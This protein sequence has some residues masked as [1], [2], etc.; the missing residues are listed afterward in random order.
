MK[1]NTVNP[2]NKSGARYDVALAKALQTKS[3]IQK[4][5]LA[6]KTTNYTA[7]HFHSKGNY[8]HRLVKNCALVFN[9]AGNTVR[10][11]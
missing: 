7:K 6:F 11:N 5:V 3:F 4:V 2:N 9:Y 10:D 8:L 1:F